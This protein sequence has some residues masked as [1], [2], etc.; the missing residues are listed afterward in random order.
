VGGVREAVAK[1]DL[2]WSCDLDRNGG[3]INQG[4]EHLL[5]LPRRGAWSGSPFSG[6]C[7]RSVPV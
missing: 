6:V 1:N 3:T 4:S 5:S 7:P 2:R